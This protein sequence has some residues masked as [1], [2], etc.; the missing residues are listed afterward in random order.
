MSATTT[1]LRPTPVVR[2]SPYGTSPDPRPV[3]LRLSGNEGAPPAEEVVVALRAV[4]ADE[5]ARY[6][7]TAALEERLARRLGVAAAAVLVTAGADDA[8][9]RICRAYLDS[10]RSGC[11]PVPGFEM[12]ERYVRLAGARVVRPRW[13]GGDFPVDAVIDA[14]PDVVFVTTPDNPTGAVVGKSDL[15]RLSAELPG[16]LLVVDLAYVEFADVDPTQTALELPNAVVLR[17]LS[18]A[19]GLAGLR[20]GYAVG[21]PDLLAPLRAVGAPYAVAGPSLRVAEAALDVDRSDY[22]ERVRT[23]RVELR[24]QLRGCGLDV[25]PSQGNFVLARGARAEWLADGLAGLG[26]GV[27]RFPG[28]PL[29]ED[30]V[31]I[32]CPG[33][34]DAFERLTAGVRA[35]L[36]PEALLFDLDGVLADVSR[37][38]RA[39]IRET[40]V[41]FGVRVTDADVARAKRAGDANDDWELTWRLVQDAGGDASLAAVTARFERLYQGADGAPGLRERESLLVERAQLE[42]LAARRPLAIV[43]G[44]PRRDAEW[45]L[46]RFGLRELFRVVVC[47]ED[48]P[49][50]PDAAPVVLACRRLGVR[51]AWMVGDTPD[52]VLAARAAGVVPLGVADPDDAETSAALLRAGAARVGRTAS[53]VLA[54]LEV[55]DA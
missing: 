31:R 30:A 46:D 38:Y 20:V 4:G 41:S 8:L 1:P 6:P 14:T 23:E 51:S 49:L 10:S 12:T 18:K 3:E 34:P 27:R 32:T 43:T 24:D 53:E 22:V 47:R 2:S 11:V 52:D 13:D 48:A 19:L 44:R 37:S 35:V 17:T 25:Q 16:A 29:L 36:T 54:A 45:F 28:R 55:C 5:L 26:I 9:D 39:A 33:R 40:A 50:K 42:R 21:R 15:R 7:S